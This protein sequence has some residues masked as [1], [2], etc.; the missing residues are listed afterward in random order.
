[1]SMPMMMMAPPGVPMTFP[2][3]MAGG[4]GNGDSSGGGVPQ[5]VIFF[6][7]PADALGHPAGGMPNRLPSRADNNSNSDTYSR[8]RNS[9]D[10]FY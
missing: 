6:A 10:N 7:Y 5:P 3:S 8:P 9:D 2:Q 1:M 4:S